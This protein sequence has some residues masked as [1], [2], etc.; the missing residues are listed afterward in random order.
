MANVTCDLECCQQCGT[1]ASLFTDAAEPIT[2]RVLTVGWKANAIDDLD[3]IPDFEA[4]KNGGVKI[5]TSA[6]TD[7]SGFDELFTEIEDDSR[8][9]LDLIDVYLTPPTALG[10]A[11]LY[12]G[13]ADFRDYITENYLS[14]WLDI[15]PGYRDLIATYESKIMLMPIG[16]H[17]APVGNSVEWLIRLVPRHSLLYLSRWRYATSVLQQRSPRLLRPAAAQDV[18]RV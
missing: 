6:S 8:L 15:L 7:V 12:D 5:D 16:K 3:V 10:S 18:G 1:G 4:A 2:L 11:A 17:D 13:F 9:G 14:E